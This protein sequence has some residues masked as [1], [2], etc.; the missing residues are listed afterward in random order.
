MV[1]FLCRYTPCVTN[2]ED[3]LAYLSIYVNSIYAGY[4]KPHLLSEVF[5]NL[6]TQ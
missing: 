6:F 3:S 5:M 2:V 4:G 1:S